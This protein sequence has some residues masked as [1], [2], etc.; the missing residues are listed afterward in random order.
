MNNKQIAEFFNSKNIYSI[1]GFNFWKGLE[2]QSGLSYGIDKTPKVAKSFNK[3]SEHDKHNVLGL[4]FNY[5]HSGYGIQIAVLKDSKTSNYLIFYRY[6][7]HYP[8]QDFTDFVKVKNIE[9]IVPAIVREII[10]NDEITIQWP[11][12]EAKAFYD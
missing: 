7:Y 5:D 10:D 3:L 4:D 9:D 1:K 8:K 11:A 6:M 12:I 2:I